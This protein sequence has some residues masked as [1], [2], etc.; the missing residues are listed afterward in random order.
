L[1]WR[2]GALHLGVADNGP[3]IPAHEHAFVFERFY[4]GTGASVSASGTGLGLAIVR[5]ACR[6]MGGDIALHNRSGG[7]CMFVATLP[8]AAP[9]GGADPASGL[10]Q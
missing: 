2:D 6:R 1:A 3:G 4:R 10:K 8:L 7:G 9:A 5:Q